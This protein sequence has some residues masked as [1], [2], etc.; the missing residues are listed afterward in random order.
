MFICV[1]VL[2]FVDEATPVTVALT[3]CRFASSGSVT[4]TLCSVLL[5]GALGTVMV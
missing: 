5:L 1:G 2:V 4:V 3:Y